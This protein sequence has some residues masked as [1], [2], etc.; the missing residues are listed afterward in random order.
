M[1]KQEVFDTLIDKI[2]AALNDNETLSK[3]ARLTPT[4]FT[5]IRKLT[6]VMI[7]YVILKGI[8]SCGELMLA[9]FY[10]NGGELLKTPSMSALSQARGKFNPKVLQ[11]MFEN[12]AELMNSCADLQLAYGCRVIAIDG[13]GLSL[14]NS[15][16][17]I[18]HYGCSG[19]KKNAATA[20]LST[21][22]D[23]VNDIILSARVDPYPVGEREAA[24]AI[25]QKVQAMP[26][27]KNHPNM[28]TADRGYPSKDILLKFMDGELGDIDE[29]GD[30]FLIRARCNFNN[31]FP[32]IKEEGFIGFERNG[33]IQRIRVI[34][35]VL[36][37]G[38]RESIF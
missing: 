24:E 18:E 23:V 31:A 8:S 20:M 9:N 17:I 33:A 35:I 4:A 11:E 28:Y 7:L 21:G 27:I 5:R 2:H 30:K 12:S 1:V 36:S 14:D 3:K 32:G 38:E 25:I 16:E 26:R 34:V 29:N 19:S 10:D 22:Y 37:T 13:S 6:A 15:D